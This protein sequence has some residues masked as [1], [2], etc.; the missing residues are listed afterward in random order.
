MGFRLLESPR[1]RDC[2]VWRRGFDVLDEDGI[3]SRFLRRNFQ[4]E[5]IL[6]R[7][8]NLRLP[9]LFGID[10]HCKR[11]IVTSRETCLV[12]H[13]AVEGV[14]EKP[15]QRAWRA[16]RMR[17]PDHRKPPGLRGLLGSVGSRSA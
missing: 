4:S 6:K 10:G 2:S 17:E 14:L 11:N 9:I 12:Y 3:H 1:G 16:V 7:R 15:G 13:R 5:L 8:T